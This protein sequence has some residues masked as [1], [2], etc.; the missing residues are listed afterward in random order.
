ME[1][2]S[3]AEWVSGIGTL[4]AVVTSLYLANRN[5]KKKLLVS[6]EIKEVVKWNPS[7]EHGEKTLI[8]TVVNMEITPVQISNLYFF[9][10]TV[11]IKLP[12]KGRVA[13]ATGK[14]LPCFVDP[15]S[16]VT[17]LVVYNDFQ[18][19][20]KEKNVSGTIAGDILV[21]DESNKKYK[22]KLKLNISANDM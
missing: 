5:P 20:L 22:S 17:F 8:V 9:S 12:I 2:G 16:E 11:R 4:L 1:V 7:P 15:F 21:V 3:M 14:N 6:H 19:E 13:L 18:S 10:G